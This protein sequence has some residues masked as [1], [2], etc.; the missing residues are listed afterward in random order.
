MGYIYLQPPSGN[1][2]EYQ[3]GNK[4]ANYFK[5]SEMR[6]PFVTESGI[7]TRLDKMEMA[8]KTYSEALD[9]GEVDEEYYN[10][11]DENG[12]VKGIELNLSKEVF[13][14]SIKQ[15]V[16]KGYFINW[17]LKDF[18][19][20][21]LDLHENVFNFNNIIYPL[22]KNNDVFLIVKV[23]KKYRTALI[24]ALISAR[25]N[26]YPVDYLL[27]PNFVLWEYSL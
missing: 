4:I 10:D 13:I 7:N 6:I 26:L 5:L 27:Y 18:I 2:S 19:L 12:Y 14:N 20:V 23:E 1:V 25:D 17:G 3:D 15:E 8:R 9:E 22:S 16:Y 21:T 24:K 11:K